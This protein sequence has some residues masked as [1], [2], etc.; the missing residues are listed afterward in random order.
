L[1]ENAEQSQNQNTVSDDEIKE[2]RL[3]LWE[4]GCLEWKLTPTQQKIYDFFHSRTDKIIVVNASRRLGKS[5]LLVVMAFEECLKNPGSIVKFLQPEVKMIRTNIRPIF[6]EL[7]LDCPLHLA[8]QYH[9]QDNIYKFPNGSQIQLAGTDNGNYMKLR[10]GNGNLILVDEAG[11]CSELDHIINYV[12][13]PTTMLVEGRIILSSTTPPAPDHDFVRLYMAEAEADGRFIRKTIYDAFE[14]DKELEK[15]RITERFIGGIISSLKNKGGAD[16]DEFRT[17]FLCEVITNSENSVIPE[18][19]KE[20]QKDCIVEWRQPAF[21]DKYVSMDIGISD[22]TVILFGFYDFDNA[23]LVITNEVVLK[24]HDVGAKNVNKFVR[25][26]EMNIWTDKM[27]GEQHEPYKRISDNNLL[28]LNDL[29][30]APYYLNFLPTEKHNKDAYINK[31]RTMVSERRIIIHPRCTTLISHLSH[32]T[33]DKNRKEFA[34]SSD[35][36]HF[37]AVD[38][39]AYL[40][41]NLDEQRNP[42][43]KGFHFNRYG[44]RGDYFINPNYI[45]HLTNNQTAI[46]SLFKK[47]KPN[48]K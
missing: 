12:L 27:T 13:V 18:F 47:R 39:L 24:G 4:M 17:E 32:A 11:F 2:A 26:M 6:D 22:L 20:I 33:W 5:F 42:Y 44:E 34:R 29:R 25:E 14:D 1:S 7:I 21:C 48:N 35:M 46:A 30:N 28:F 38:A 43:P 23:V 37:D 8:P 15:P 40:V 45:E 3:K 41:R 9:T 16:S 10:G 36:G 19:N 31:L